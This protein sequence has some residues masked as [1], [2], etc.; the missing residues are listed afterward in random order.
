MKNKQK[1]KGKKKFIALAAV[2]VAAAV[3]GVAL[4]GSAQG[5]K[6]EEPDSYRYHRC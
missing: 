2:G 3:G 4:Y 6:A 5:N 1:K